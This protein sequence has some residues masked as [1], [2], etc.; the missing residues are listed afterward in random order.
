MAPDFAD[1]QSFKADS[2]VC[3]NVLEHIEH[4]RDALRRMA[5]VL[6]PG[7]VVIL[8]VPASPRLYG[9]TI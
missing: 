2:C 3:L 8:L 6:A 9:P 4:D 1:L 5:G 7:G